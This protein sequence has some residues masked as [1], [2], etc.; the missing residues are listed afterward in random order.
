MAAITGAISSFGS[1]AGGWAATGAGAL[2]ASAN[3]ANIV[4]AVSSAAVQGA[5]YGAII[6]GGQAALTGGNI[7]KG[8]LTGAAIGGVVGGVIQGGGMAAG[9]F[10]T[11]GQAFSMGGAG[12]T[13]NTAATPNQEASLSGGFGPE[14]VATADTRAAVP[15]AGAG[16]PATP[17]TPPTP[18]VS[19]PTKGLMYSG[20]L[21]GGFS[22]IGALGAEMMKEDAAEDAAKKTTE[23]DVE[24]AKELQKLNVAGRYQGQVAN[25]QLPDW[26]SKYIKPQVATSPTTSSGGLLGGTA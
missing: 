2:G 20:A 21:Q 5:V 15:G 4:G 1:W 10:D 12:E 9:V 17:P 16:T 23:Q 26:Y 19:D 8:A 7:F 18:P 14:N 25:I 11:S 6:G 22:G 13:I 3:V 24:K